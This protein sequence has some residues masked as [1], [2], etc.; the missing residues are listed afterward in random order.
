MERYDNA[1]NPVLEKATDEELLPLVECMLKKL[2]NE[3]DCDDR[4]KKNPQKPTTYVDLLADELRLFGGNTIAN[5][6]RGGVGVSYNEVVCDVANKLRISYNKN[7][8]IERIEELILQKV[9]EDRVEQLSEEEKSIFLK[10]MGVVGIPVGASATMIAQMILKIGGFKSYQLAVIVANFIAKIFLGRGLS[11]AANAALTK[12]LSFFVGPV[13]W[14]ASALWML[15]D[16]A[17]PSYRTTIPCVAYI[18]ALRRIQNSS[19]F[20]NNEN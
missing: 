1:L 8:K 4:Y 13:G 18:A 5:F 2:S 10:E 11:F 17:G 19:S 6:F 15:V 20:L 7:S 14:G 9:F 16:I 3:I 12:S